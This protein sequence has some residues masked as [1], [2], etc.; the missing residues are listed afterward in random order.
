MGGLETHDKQR[1]NLGLLYSL[2]RFPASGFLLLTLPAIW[3]LLIK[4]LIK[5]LISVLLE[6]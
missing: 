3:L 5:L 2:H 6:E 4:L 1:Q